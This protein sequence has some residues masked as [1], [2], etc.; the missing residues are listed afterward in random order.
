MTPLTFLSRLAALIPA[1]RANLTTYHGLLAPAASY[2]DRVIPEPTDSHSTLRDPKAAPIDAAVRLS[3]EQK[4]RKLVWAEAM[5]R[6]L[7]IDVL[8]C[9]HCGGQRRRC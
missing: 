8:T 4:R 6:G 2:R 5:K 3:K 1:P 9:E 7:G